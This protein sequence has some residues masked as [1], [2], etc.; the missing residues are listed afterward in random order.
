M[1]LSIGKYII[2]KIDQKH[3][4]FCG[5]K[6]NARLIDLSKLGICGKPRDW[7]FGDFEII[8]TLL[9]H[10]K[11]EMMHSMVYTVC[12]YLVDLP[13][14]VSGLSKRDLLNLF[15]LSKFYMNC[16]KFVLE[17]WFQLCLTLKHCNPEHNR[18]KFALV[19][20]LSIK[21]F[22]CC[23]WYTRGFNDEDYG[24]VSNFLADKH[25]GEIL[26]NFK[27]LTIGSLVA[28]AEMQNINYTQMVIDLFA[29]KCKNIQHLSFIYGLYSGLTLPQ[30]LSNLISIVISGSLM[31]EL[32]IS[33][34][35]NLI[36]CSLGIVES[37][38]SLILPQNLNASNDNVLRLHALRINNNNAIFAMLNN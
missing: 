29:E 38:A 21:V 19:N 17:K 6:W 20:R 10:R 27:I 12:Q 25:V 24:K 15:S 7:I 13:A 4:R 11:A 1:N 18:V 16:R 35:N 2:Q 32:D 37:S 3:N 5:A 28:P 22:L 36:Y 23:F 33:K 26:S 9:D 8:Q 31:S 30:N 14:I 34:I